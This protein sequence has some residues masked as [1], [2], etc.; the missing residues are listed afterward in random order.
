MIIDGAVAGAARQ[1]V[2]VLEPDFNFNCNLN[3][4]FN[5]NFNIEFNFNFKLNFNPKLNFKLELGIIRNE[6]QLKFWRRWRIN[7]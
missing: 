6:Q 3:F 4:N 1:I 2:L 7:S 5:F